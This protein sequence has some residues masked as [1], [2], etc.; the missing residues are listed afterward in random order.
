MYL[1]SR[2]SAIALQTLLVMVT[3]VDWPIPTN[4]RWFYIL[5]FLLTYCYSLPHRNSPSES[6]IFPTY[7]RE[8]L[9]AQFDEGG[10]RKTE[11]ILPFPFSPIYWHATSPHQADLA[12]SQIVRCTVGLLL[13][14]KKVTIKLKRMAVV[15]TREIRLTQRHSRR[16]L[17]PSK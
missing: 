2:W 12:F 4:E 11:V 14:L 9:R 5:H 7:E 16:L 17:S 15:T 13:Q 10:P 3:A 1:L 8:K 6:S